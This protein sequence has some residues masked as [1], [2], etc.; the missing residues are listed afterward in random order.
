MAIARRFPRAGACA[1]AIALAWIPAH[2]R[3]PSDAPDSAGAT[4]AIPLRELPTLDQ[5]IPALAEHRVVFV[6][7]THSRLDHHRI[8]LEILRQ[9]A[10]RHDD[11]MIGVEWFQQPYQDA[12]DAYLGGAIDERELLRRTEYYDRWRFDFRHYAPI[13]QFARERAIPV[14]ALNLPAEVTRA[15][16][17]RD[18]QE[19]EPELRRWI[20]ED[21]DRSDED[22]RRRLRQAFDAHPPREHSDFERF[23]AT[24]LLWDEGMAARAA[25]ALE[26]HPERRLLVFAGSGHVAF[27]AG[28]PNRLRRRTGIDSAIVLPDWDGPPERGLADFLLLSEPQELP[29]PGRLGVTLEP[30]AGRL[31]ITG[32]EEGGAAAAAG[33]EEGDILLR[34]AGVPVQDMGDVRAALWDR[35]PG[36]VVS[37]TVRRAPLLGAPTTVSVDAT[38]R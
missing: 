29:Q 1:L 34:I 25:E 2:A 20:P 23:Y 11:L 13:L 9:L 32:L 24:Q 7:E 14:I 31:A 35:R 10:A 5:I 19:L 27:G 21:I 36:D 3:S 26:R 18:L 38:L 16:A 15:S 22:Y 17:R 6:G 30:G 4:P 28:I 33:L 37:V 12:L 8:Q